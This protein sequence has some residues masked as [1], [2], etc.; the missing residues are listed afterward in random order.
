MKQKLKQDFHKK[1]EEETSKRN[2]LVSKIREQKLKQQLEA[3]RQ[4]KELVLMAKEDIFM[5]Q[6]KIREAEMKRARVLSASNRAKAKK[7]AELAEK[8][9]KFPVYHQHHRPNGGK[10]SKVKTEANNEE[11]DDE[12]EV[13]EEEIQQKKKQEVLLKRIKEQMEVKMQEQKQSEMNEK[14]RK[15]KLA[16]VCNSFLTFGL[17]LNHSLPIPTCFLVFKAI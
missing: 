6:K 10:V 17:C 12:K 4:S 1:L 13:D 7:E 14:Q 3:E 11:E 16:Q 5:I 15:E 8:P 2:Q 9:P